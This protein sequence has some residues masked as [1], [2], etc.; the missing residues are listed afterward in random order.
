[1]KRYINFKDDNFKET[2]DEFEVNSKEQRQE[3]KRCF[4]EYLLIYPSSQFW[5]SQK[6]CNNWNN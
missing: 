1:M 4:K 6:P 3:L 2:I 5:V